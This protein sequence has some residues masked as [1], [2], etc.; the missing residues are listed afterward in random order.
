MLSDNGEWGS[1]H[2][3]RYFFT[4]RFEDFTKT[5]REANAPNGPIY[6]LASRAR[7]FG[8][9]VTGVIDRDHETIPVRVT[10]NLNYELPQIAEGS[11]RR[12]RPEPLVLT[13]IVSEMKAG[14]VYNLYRYNQLNTVPNGDFNKYAANAQQKWVITAGASGRFVVTEKILSDEV[15]AYRAVPA[16]AP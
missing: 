10:T 8:V 9:A 16:D 14:A 12:P 11:S 2:H 15:A 1:L 7:D 4:Y 5:R 13:V 6:S 3:A